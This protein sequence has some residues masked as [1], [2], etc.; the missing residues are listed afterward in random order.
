MNVVN[1]AFRGAGK[2]AVAMSFS[3]ITLLGL[4]VPLAYS[5]AGFTP[6]GTPGLWWGV[7]LS[8]IIGGVAATLWFRRGDWK[9]RLVPREEEAREVPVPGP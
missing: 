3:I 8:N 7:C 2:T 5:L 1:G 4:R 9:Q 6:L